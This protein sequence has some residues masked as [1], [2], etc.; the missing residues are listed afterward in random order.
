MEYSKIIIRD[1]LGNLMI[2]G[3]TFLKQTFA[4]INYKIL[5]KKKDKKERKSYISFFSFFSERDS[6]SSLGLIYTTLTSEYVTSIVSI[7]KGRYQIGES[8][9][10]V[11]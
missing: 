3:L 9:I 2:N 4:N 11:K 1:L 7:R 8:K 10:L 6:P 5:R